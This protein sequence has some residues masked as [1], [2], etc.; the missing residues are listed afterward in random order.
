MTLAELRALADEATKKWSPAVTDPEW[1]TVQD[2]RRILDDLGPDLARLCAELGEA[3]EFS[4]T[5]FALT[6]RDGFREMLAKREAALAKL[7]E[8]KS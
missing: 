8:L 6:C 1:R 3:L 7:S 2:A 5:Q 4:G